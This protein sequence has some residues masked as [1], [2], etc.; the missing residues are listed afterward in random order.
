MSQP[1]VPSP[2]ARRGNDLL[3]KF[4]EEVRAAYTR[5]LATG[6]VEAVDL[7]ALAVIKD[8]IPKRPGGAPKPE[9]ND[10]TRL[11]TD[12]GF[13]SLT[14]AESVFFFEDLFR[15]RINNAEI[16]QVTTVGELRNFIRRKVAE[17]PE[18]PSAG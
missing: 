1:P 6:E 8:F 9:F 15:V 11:M 4:P 5:Y 2:S 16:M 17:I 12:L 3:A 14:I 13:D 18:A 10:S 7:I